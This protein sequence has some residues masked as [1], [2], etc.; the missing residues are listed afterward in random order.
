MR[1]TICKKIKDKTHSMSRHGGGNYRRSGR[2]YRG[3]VCED[4]ILEGALSPYQRWDGYETSSLRGIATVILGIRTYQS[5]FQVWFRR[6]GR[7][8]VHSTLSSTLYRFRRA[9]AEV[10]T[11]DERRTL[12]AAWI[13]GTGEQYESHV[14][15]LTREHRNRVISKLV[16]VYLPA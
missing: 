1:C 5:D 10:S 3:E 8:T 4:C 2:L 6:K 14:N 16:A 7:E 15:D 9:W 13:A 11:D 12:A